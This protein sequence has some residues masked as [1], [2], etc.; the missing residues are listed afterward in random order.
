MREASN[1]SGLDRHIA[2]GIAFLALAGELL[3]VPRMY[4]QLCVVAYY[5]RL[6]IGAVTGGPCFCFADMVDRK[7]P[8]IFVEG[9]SSSSPLQSTL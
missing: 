7:L 5:F 2:S 8:C 3:N 6:S 9:A 1:L 4:P